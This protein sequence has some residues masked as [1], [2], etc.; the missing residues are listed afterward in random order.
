MKKPLAL[1]FALLLFSAT[2]RA[3]TVPETEAQ[4]ATE[5]YIYFYPLVTMDVT[6]RQAINVEAGQVLGRGPMNTFVNIP[7]FP[8]ADFRDV[9]RPNFDTLYTASWLDLTKGPVVVTTPDTQGR[10]YLLPLLDMWTDVFAVP[11]SRTTGTAAHTFVVARQGWKGELPKGAQLIE[12]PT[13]YTWAIGRTQ[14]N[15]PEDFPAVNKIQAGFTITEL[16]QW[17]SGKKA[18]VQVAIDPTVDMKTPPLEQ[19]NKMPADKFFSYAAELMKVNPPH[20]TDQPIIARL[21][22]IGIEPGKSFSSDKASAAVKTSLTKARTEGLKRI[23]AY[24]AK[25]TTINGWQMNT[26]T[27]GVYGNFYLKRASVAMNGLGANLP[28]DAIYP[29]GV[30]DNQGK[31]LTGKNKYLLKFK[32]SELPPVDAFWSLTLYDEDGFQVAN[33]LDRFALGD[34]DKLK[35]NADGSLELYVQ[36]KSPGKEKEANWLPAPKGPFTLLLRLYSPKQEV[37]DGR[38]VPSAIKKV[39]DRIN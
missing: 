32:K 36:N 34:R 19:V 13:A 8:P 38:W 4:I 3:D 5:A 27:M 9:V 17:N 1:F 22:R 18:D 35:Y 23:K 26:D 31:A 39:D 15:G 7:A 14:T 2:G 30:V 16:S 10:Y 29:F 37:L 24:A 28:E 20:I 33:S 11:G 25:A 21:K 12:S 6:R